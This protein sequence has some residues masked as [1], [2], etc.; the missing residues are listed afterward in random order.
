[1]TKDSVLPTVANVI[2]VI[3]GVLFISD[4]FTV[5]KYM[6][7]EGILSDGVRIRLLV[8]QRDMVRYFV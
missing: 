6:P 5:R 7:N 4:I 1:M 8:A 2:L 3:I